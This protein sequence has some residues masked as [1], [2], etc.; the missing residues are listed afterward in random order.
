MLVDA[1][2]LDA[3]PPLQCWRACCL[4]LQPWSSSADAPVCFIQPLSHC[5][6]RAYMAGILQ[7]ANIG[8]L[9]S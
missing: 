9:K 1:V 4:L 8:I 6:A 7:L 2:Q 5:T 3:R